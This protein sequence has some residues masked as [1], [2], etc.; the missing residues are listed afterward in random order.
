[1]LSKSISLIF[2]FWLDIVSAFSNVNTR[3]GLAE[4]SQVLDGMEGLR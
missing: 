2:F 4:L 3:E 1:M